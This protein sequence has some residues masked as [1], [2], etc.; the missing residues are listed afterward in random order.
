MGD[1]KSLEN[2]VEEQD[3]YAF[4]PDSARAR[5]HATMYNKR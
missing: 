2:T 1:F 4:E 5:R 3:F